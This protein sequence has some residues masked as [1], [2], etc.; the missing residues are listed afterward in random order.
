VRYVLSPRFINECKSTRGKLMK[1]GYGDIKTSVN[2]EGVK[3]IDG[4][5][6]GRSNNNATKN[7]MELREN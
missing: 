4:S 3:G 2:D 6:E 7:A 1:V 5:F